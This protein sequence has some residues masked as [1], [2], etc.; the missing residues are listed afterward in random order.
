[1]K[2][3][4]AKRFA[5]EM[6]LKNRAFQLLTVISTGSPLLNASCIRSAWSFIPKIAI[7]GL[8]TMPSKFFL[9]FLVKQIIPY[10][11]FNN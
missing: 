6:P 10:A 9:F 11:F 4:S 3:R 7:S 8:S 5:W 1:M 2:I